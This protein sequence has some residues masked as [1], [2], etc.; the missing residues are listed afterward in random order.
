VYN[1]YGKNKLMEIRIIV[2]KTANIWYEIV[3]SD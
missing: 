1:F 2:E 3:M